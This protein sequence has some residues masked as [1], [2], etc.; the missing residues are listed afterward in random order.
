MLVPEEAVVAAEDDQ[1]V[2]EFTR[3]PQRLE[4]SPDTLIDRDDA[5]ELVADEI[6]ADAVRG[7]AF[8]GLG[9]FARQGGLSLEV[10]SF[11]GIAR[12]RVFLEELGMPGAG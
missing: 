5:A 11:T 8:L 3:V 2:V 12:Q 1:R 6:V 9:N 10:V 7:V 4:D